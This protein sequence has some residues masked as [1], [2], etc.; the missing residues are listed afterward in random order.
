MKLPEI[1]RNALKGYRGQWANID[2]LLEFV[3]PALVQDAVDGHLDTLIKVEI[4]HAIKALKDEDGEPLFENVISATKG[5]TEEKRYKQLALF[6][7]ED[8]VDCTKSYASR[9]H[10]QMRRANEL[11][12]RCK[13]QTGR[14]IP[15]P[16]PD[17]DQI[18]G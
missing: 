17:F 8:F 7:F 18:A 15:L 10:G 16:F 4:R 5:G 3:R 2:G 1:I 13:R 12:K 11:A 14:R 6:T 9:A